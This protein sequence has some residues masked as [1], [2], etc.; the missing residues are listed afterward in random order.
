MVL[1]E[2]AT[3]AFHLKT[4]MVLAFSAVSID[5]RYVRACEGHSSR[6]RTRERSSWCTA[7]AGDDDR[8]ISSEKDD[9][10]W[11]L[12]ISWRLNQSEGKG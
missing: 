1:E 7:A 3:T 12:T 4:P 8:G 9:Y 10:T 6:Q 5:T 11:N 2:K